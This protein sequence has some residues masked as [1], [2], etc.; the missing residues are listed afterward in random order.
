MVSR[1]SPVL[2]YRWQNSFH[3][4]LCSQRHAHFL[5]TGEVG[6][7]NAFYLPCKSF[8]RNF[9]EVCVPGSSLRGGCCLS[10]CPVIFLSQGRLLLVVAEVGAEWESGEL[11]ACKESMIAF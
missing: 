11:G 3:F 8:L 5:K 6:S 7:G 9:R 4:H 2:K 1:D 10:Q